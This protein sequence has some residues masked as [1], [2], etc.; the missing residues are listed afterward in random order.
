MKKQKP[1]VAKIGKEFKPI[2]FKRLGEP[3]HVML[4]PFPYIVHNGLRVIDEMC[5][6]SHRRSEHQDTLAYGHGAL[7]DRPNLCKKFTWVSFIF[8]N[9]YSARRRKKA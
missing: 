3:G 5:S 9:P 1:L 6:C 2:P 4:S 8:E 7:R